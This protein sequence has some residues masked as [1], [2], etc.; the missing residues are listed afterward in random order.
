MEGFAYSFTE[1]EE[2]PLTRKQI[3]AAVKNNSLQQGLD[4]KNSSLFKRSWEYMDTQGIGR[5]TLRQLGAGLSQIT[6]AGPPQQAF[7]FSLV[8]VNLNSALSFE[9]V[10]LPH[11]SRTASLPAPNPRD[12]LTQSLPITPHGLTVGV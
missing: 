7:V 12:A 4:L 3:R 5:I 9:E 8:D 6:R 2:S 1:R 11:A 10:H